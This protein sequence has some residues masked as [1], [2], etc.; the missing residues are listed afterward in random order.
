MSMNETFFGLA[1]HRAT[2]SKEM[3]GAISPADAD[4][5]YEA[6]VTP[7]RHDKSGAAHDVLEGLRQKSITRIQQDPTFSLTYGID[8]TALSGLGFNWLAIIQWIEKNLPT[9]LADLAA[10]LAL[11]GEPV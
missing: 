7:I 1:L 6:I 5:I 11:F 9:I 2:R 3:A 10:L 8:S 4:Q